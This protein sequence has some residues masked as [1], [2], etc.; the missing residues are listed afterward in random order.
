[1]DNDKL[2]TTAPA[3]KRMMKRTMPSDPAATAFLLDHR[4]RRVLEPFFRTPLSLSDAARTANMKLNTRHYRVE[5]LPGQGTTGSSGLCRGDLSN[6][7]AAK[8]AEAAGS[9]STGQVPTS[10]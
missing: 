7:P 9:S 4:E 3:L 8:C 5:A 6:R 1:M 10:S 2:Q